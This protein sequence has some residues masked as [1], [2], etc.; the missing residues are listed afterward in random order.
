MS[1]DNVKYNPVSPF[2]AGLGCLCPRCGQT[3][4][5]SG[6]L[7]LKNHCPECGLDYGPLDAADGPAFFVMTIVSFIVIGLVLWVEFSYGPPLWLH[8]LMW[9]P[10]TVVLSVALLRPVKG[11]FVA[12][13]YTHQAEEGRL[14]DG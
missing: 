14:K 4:I 12:L 3:R 13:Q 7:Q 5:Y 10:L 9:I 6:F 8:M 11:L 1:I 2:R